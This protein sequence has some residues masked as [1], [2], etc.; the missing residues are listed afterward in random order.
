[1]SPGF[2]AVLLHKEYDDDRE[3][4]E[5]DDEENEEEEKALPEFTKGEFIPVSATSSSRSSSS[6]VSVTAAGSRATLGITEKKT[7]PPSHLTE[8]EL[9]NQMEKHGI[10]TDASI[11]THIENI[12]KRN[13]AELHPGRRMHPSKL[14]LVLA[15]GYHLID[16]G[17]VLPKVRSDIES[18]CNKIAKGLA[19]KVSRVFVNQFHFLFIEKI[20]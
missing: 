3:Q 15:Q 10:G 12:L 13:Y 16:S 18:E 7:T 19:D 1:M 20:C 9:I 2:L 6:K 11:A 17:L 5:F 4:S 14:G 8:S